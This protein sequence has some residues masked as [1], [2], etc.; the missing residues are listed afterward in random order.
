[1]Q[2]EPPVYPARAR[3]RGIEGWVDLEFFV[4]AEGRPYAITVTDAEP[5]GEFDTAALEAAAGY[6]YVP[7][8]LDGRTYERR[9][10]LR[11][12]FALE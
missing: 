6:L 12:R 3:A 7:F 4:D 10:S 5:A 2:F 8:E 1:M 9:V 11:M